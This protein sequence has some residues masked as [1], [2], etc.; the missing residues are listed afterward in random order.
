MVKATYPDRPSFPR[1]FEDGLERELGGA[2]ATRVSSPADQR[3]DAAP[4]HHTGLVLTSG[5]T[6][7]ITN[8]SGTVP[9]G[10]VGLGW[11]CNYRCRLSNWTGLDSHIIISVIS[12]LCCSY[13]S[14]SYAYA[15]VVRDRVDGREGESK[16]LLWRLLREMRNMTAGWSRPSPAPVPAFPGF[17]ASSR[18]LE[19]FSCGRHGRDHFLIDPAIRFSNGAPHLSAR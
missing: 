14:G 15:Q 4:T 9:G 13:V 18:W 10:G 2:G 5:A 3:I 7:E 8:G 1:E 16:H 11:P 6:G 12:A 19:M 17:Q